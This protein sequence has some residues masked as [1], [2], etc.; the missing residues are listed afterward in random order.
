MRILLLVLASIFFSSCMEKEM[1]SYSPAI[2]SDS[3]RYLA[4]GDS[5]TIGQSVASNLNFPHQLQSKLLA[6]GKGNWEV[7]IIAQTGWTTSNL[8]SAIEQQNPDSSYDLVSLLIGVNN[9]YQQMD[10][11]VYIREFRELLED[12]IAFG[13]GDYKR[14]MVLSIPDYG[15]SPFGQQRDPAKISEQTDQYNRIALGICKE[16]GVQFIDITGI[17]RSSDKSMF[18][19][20]GLHPSALQYG[21]W[22]DEIVKQRPF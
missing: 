5:Y 1:K 19:S 21:M 15:Y 16:K 7:D 18:A 9:F 3:S 17:S 4:L 11:Q 22:V 10:S 14:V 13:K 6:S 2:S 8:K 20:D 12:A